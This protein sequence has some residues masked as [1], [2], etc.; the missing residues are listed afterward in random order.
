MTE[1]IQ[2]DRELYQGVYIV[3]HRVGIGQAEHELMAEARAYEFCRPTQ[4]ASK[5]LGRIIIEHD[6]KVAERM[7]SK[8]DVS[9]WWTMIAER[10]LDR[11]SLVKGLFFGR[12]TDETTDEPRD[13]SRIY[14]SHVSG[15]LANIYS[16][17][18]ISDAFRLAIKLNLC[19]ILVA[20]RFHPQSDV[21]DVVAAAFWAGYFPL[22]WSGKWPKG[23]LVVYG[24][25]ERQPPTSDVGTIVVDKA[26]ALQTV[27]KN[28]EQLVERHH[29]HPGYSSAPAIA[30]HYH[31]QWEA[32]AQHGDVRSLVMHFSCLANG[33]NERRLLAR[34]FA[35]TD[36][37][38]VKRGELVVILRVADSG[39]VSLHCRPPWTAAITRLP[40][41]IIPI[42]HHH[43]G[44]RIDDSGK[45]IV[46][47]PFNGTDFDIGKEWR[48]DIKDDGI[49]D[50]EP[51]SAAPLLIPL[52]DG[53][54]LYVY[55][56][57]D[58]TSKDG[59]PLMH[60]S[61]ETADV[62]DRMKTGVGGMFL[63]MVAE[64]LN[65]PSKP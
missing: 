40:R 12:K 19:D 18:K 11:H 1:M 2:L 48:R 49:L 45:P 17:K 61:H 36:K 26:T 22:Q 15:R 28:T 21:V 58:V 38:M 52:T 53:Q 51:W 33:D 39:K 10:G 57:I 20:A 46:L 27:K 7:L 63:R 35:C 14:L 23:H 4:A 43:N 54:D 55:H 64:R 25:A 13:F 3:G 41:E 62:E 8:N 47:F 24:P 60:L 42:L 16:E 9:N 56:P 31:A 44:L 29:A 59:V 6:V 30:E 37:V 34:I 50:Y 65:I 5:I 32:L